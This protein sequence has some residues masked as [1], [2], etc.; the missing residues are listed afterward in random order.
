M[1]FKTALLVIILGH[2]AVTYAEN[3][4]DTTGLPLSGS[5]VTIVPAKKMNLPASVA[6][7]QKLRAFQLKTNGY[8][9][10]ESSYPKYLVDMGKYG[11]KGIN[12]SFNAA[13][14]NMKY[15]PDQIKLGYEYHPIKIIQSEN[16]LG[17][18]ASGTYIKD[19]GWSGIDTF[20]NF[21]NVGTCKYSLDNMK[22]TNGAVEISA[23]TVRYDVNKKPTD[24]FVQGSVNSGFVYS[25][26][27]FDNSFAHALDCA[28]M[29][30]DKNLIEQVIA[31][32]NK[33][34]KS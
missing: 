25:V 16:I 20:F 10:L 28:S 1:K 19:K 18:S 2:S 9:M 3:N 14:T 24:I 30:Y 11:P 31:L 6:A 23:E 22:L 26:N 34:D 13:D 4:V 5:G 7:S 21:K 8:I 33:I 27:W 12:R 17:Y 29:N 32:A 15:S